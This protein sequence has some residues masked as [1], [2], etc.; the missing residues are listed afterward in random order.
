SDS[1]DLTGAGQR[2]RVGGGTVKGGHVMGSTLTV[3]SGTLDGVTV[4]GTG[5]IGVNFTTA[6][7]VVQNGLTLD[8][9]MLTV[10]RPSAGGQ[11]INFNGIQQIGGTGQ[12]MFNELP[13]W[14][15]TLQ[16]PTNASLTIG[17]GVVVTAQS[18]V[19]IGMGSTS[20]ANEGS[21]S[22]GV[23]TIGSA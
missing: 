22:T 8:H 16:L 13:S 23:L 4:G 11:T 21:I 15:T 7:I 2:L 10:R 12:I 5:T 18:P 19:S 1:L 20:F 17:P 14:A 9:A 6:S 3:D